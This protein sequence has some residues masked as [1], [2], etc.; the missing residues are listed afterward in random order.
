MNV[1]ES[2]K[3][4]IFFCILKEFLYKDLF[5]MTTDILFDLLADGLTDLQRTGIVVC[6]NSCA[7]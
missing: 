5:D 1:I 4:N 3:L 7:V 6:K 2:P